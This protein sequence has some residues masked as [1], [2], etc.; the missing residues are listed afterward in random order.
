MITAEKENLLIKKIDNKLVSE[1]DCVKMYRRLVY[2]YAHDYT[3]FNE[4][5]D[6]IQ[7]GFLGLIKA[8][9]AYDE[10]REANFIS[11]AVPYIKGSIKHYL[12][13]KLRIIRQ[14]RSVT[15]LAVL[16]NKEENKE[17]TVKELSKK[18]KVSEKEIESVIHS[19]KPVQSI[20]SF[21][22]YQGLNKTE[23]FNSDGCLSS[24]QD[25]TAI[26][27]EEFLDT[28]TDNERT[29]M[30]LRLLDKTQKCIADK[31]GIRQMQVSRILKRIG[32][33]YNQYTA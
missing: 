6:I 24:K 7:E 4:N 32:A 8:F 30:N 25:F 2:Y 27:V 19:R 31:M 33:K 23:Q 10:T 14:P 29:I 20:D 13:D 9:R 11:L 3:D 16:L 15:E 18:L 28:L 5:E 1:D 26:Y 21:T 12:R 22:K 17:L